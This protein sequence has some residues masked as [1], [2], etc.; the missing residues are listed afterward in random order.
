MEEEN[1]ME[2]SEETANK[3]GVLR[4]D[5]LSPDELEK[6]L[7]V[8][9]ET[10]THDKGE[11]EG[12]AE[13]GE[14]KEGDTEKEGGDSAPAG[15]PDDSTSA[16]VSRSSVKEKTIDDLKFDQQLTALAGQTVLVQPRVSRET[17]VDVLKQH[18][19]LMRDIRRELNVTKT[20]VSSLV[21]LTDK[22]SK[23]IEVLQKTSE[24]EK[25]KV[26]ALETKTTRMD[27]EIQTIKDTL[28][29]LANIKK[30][31][32]VLKS[33][34]TEIQANMKAQKLEIKESFE[35]VDSSLFAMDNMNKETQ[36]LLKEL[37]EYVDHFGDNL[38]LASTQITVESKVGFSDRPMT[39]QD[40]LKLLKKDFGKM[41]F[42]QE[43]QRN[44]IQDNT[45]AILTK[46]D[47][48]V[49]L[50]V[51]TL[52]EKV[53]AIEDHL[54][55]EAE[56]GLS[57][58]RKNCEELSVTVDHVLADLTEKVDRKSVDLIVHNKYE[59][60]VEYLQQA[61]HADEED[62]DTQ[63]ARAKALQEDMRSLA[64][65]KADR[66]EIVAIQEALV[67]AEANMSKM[68][69]IVEKAPKDTL[70][71]AQIEQL[72][73]NKVDKEEFAEHMTNL[74]K[75]MKKNR[76]SAIMHGGNFGADE[77]QM[78]TP[79]IPGMARSQVNFI[80]SN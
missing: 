26:Q 39:L 72:L 80:P 53:S 43:D 52:N 32:K 69:K 2:N 3:E 64:A 51:N 78:M 7:D 71:T 73:F 13:K 77:A 4:A 6:E 56:E 54:K 24:E 27:D 9:S 62:G 30:E 61:L 57:A 20:T 70:S 48:T 15:D 19:N 18:T 41:E 10:N 5:D 40:V 74:M 50:E 36:S 35:S 37:K 16:A 33:T 49:Q 75:S 66:L 58:L 45:D 25:L 46:A 31:Q 79:G 17:I 59:D 42:A 67:K 12:D 1:V 8:A 65:T 22:H 23:Y 34:L 68:T 44:K 38:I 60:I 76:K 55:A 63:A 21:T 28:G 47:A 11:V 29:E 14:K